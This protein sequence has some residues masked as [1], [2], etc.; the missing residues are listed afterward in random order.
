[1][2]SD[3]RDRLKLPSLM[4]QFRFLSYPHV[5]A[6]AYILLCSMPVATLNM[7]LRE[8]N[9]ALNSTRMQSLIF[10]TQNG[11]IPLIGSRVWLEGL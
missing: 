1:M 4:V 10:G 9:N 6:V 2:K 5:A 7:E 3:V 11:T 8:A